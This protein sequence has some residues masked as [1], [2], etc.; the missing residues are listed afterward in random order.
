MRISNKKLEEQEQPPFTGTTIQIFF[1]EKFR[2]IGIVL[3]MKKG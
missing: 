2:F 1:L 3:F